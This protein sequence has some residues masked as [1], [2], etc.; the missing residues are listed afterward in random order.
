MIFMLAWT[1]HTT[2][3]PLGLAVGAPA[4]LAYLCTRRP[5]RF[6]LSIGALFWFGHLQSGPIG[7]LLHADRT[8]FGVYRVLRDDRSTVLI[9]GTTM[10]GEQF[11]DPERTGI[12]LGYYH[13]DGP[14]GHVFELFGD[15]PL[16]DR[17]GL[18]GLGTGSLAAY[19]RPGQRMTF[20]EIDPA[21]VRFA[22]NPAWFTYL[23]DSRAEVGVVLGDG[24]LSLRDHAGEGEF[25][26]I[27]L[28]AFTSDAIPVHLLTREAVALYV[29][30]L[31]PGGL[32]ALHLS[33]QYLDLVPV[34]G[35]V[36]GTLGFAAAE[37]N[38]TAI[39]RAEALATGRMACHWVVLARSA[40]DLAP[41]LGD[42]RWRLLTPDP[43]A[44]LWTDDYSNIVG[45]MD[46]E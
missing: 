19:G 9:H 20:F 28:D 14:I 40:P 42:P 23:R 27:V 44:P 3:L 41:L 32:L 12:P 5:L 8:F 45:V 39:D 7:W 46:W 31:R 10:H 37:R 26:L 34:A 17:V 30:R 6:A 29:S 22:S 25:G 36:A 43:A 2:V 15:R 38:D 21:V 13:P 4:L 35:R 1:L 33:N 11:R 16:F 18:V 24:R